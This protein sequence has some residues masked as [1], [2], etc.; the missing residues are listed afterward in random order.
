M[1]KVVVQVT[2]A[3]QIPEARAAAEA[4]M[5]VGDEL[6][7][8]IVAPTPLPAE[9]QAPRRAVGYAPVKRG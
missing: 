7:I 3:D 9:R 1:V 6:E 5:L 4:T 8:T 2:S